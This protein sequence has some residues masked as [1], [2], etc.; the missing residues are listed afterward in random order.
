MTGVQHHRLFIEK[1]CHITEGVGRI[2][3][4]RPWGLMFVTEAEGMPK[5]ME[6]EFLFNLLVLIFCRCGIFWDRSD[7]KCK[8][9]I[10]GSAVSVDVSLIPRCICELFSNITPTKSALLRYVAKPDTNVSRLIGRKSSIWSTKPP[11]YAGHA[12]CGNMLLL[13]LPVRM[14]I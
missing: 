13:Y 10:S 1:S 7:R 8:G 3:C 6:Q 2:C 12:F 9:R 5:L 14:C 4:F 11:T